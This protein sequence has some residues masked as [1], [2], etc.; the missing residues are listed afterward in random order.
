MAFIHR[1]GSSLNEHVHFHVCVVDGVFE[2]LP[3]AQSD[4]DLPESVNAPS[5][6]FHP[7]QI[8]EAA[9]AQMQATVRKRLL[10]AFVARGHL[11]SHDAKDMN[12]RAATAHAPASL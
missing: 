2:M 10:R 9:M 3:G 8:D 12:E 7:A 5:I 6:K 11:E 4:A 1:F